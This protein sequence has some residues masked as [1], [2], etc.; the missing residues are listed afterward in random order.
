MTALVPSRTALATSVTS[1]RVGTGDAIIDSS[2]WVAVMT[3][4]PKRTAE[5]MICF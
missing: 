1:A 4:R 2:I 5:K 3:G